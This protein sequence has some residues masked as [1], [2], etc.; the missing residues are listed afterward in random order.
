MFV[1]LILMTIMPRSKPTAKPNKL[2]DLAA[3]LSHLKMIS[4]NL[5]VSFIRSFGSLMLKSGYEGL[6]QNLN[7]MS[8]TRD[9]TLN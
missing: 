7:A 1:D 3:K 4:I 2:S 8:I 5:R 9:D 6:E